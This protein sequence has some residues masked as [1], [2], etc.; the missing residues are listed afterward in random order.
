MNI[1]D[2]ILEEIKALSIK[3]T[4]QEAQ[5]LCKNYAISHF[6]VIENDKL[7]GCFAE[8]DIRTIEDTNKQLEEFIHLFNHFFVTEKTPFLDLITLFANN[9]S[10]L[11]PVLNKQHF[12]IGYYELSDV[13]ELFAASPFLH[14][15]NE[16]LVISKTENDYSMSQIAQIVESNKSKLLG[17]YISDKSN[18]SVQITLKI[19]STEINEIIQ[20][21]RRYDYTVLTEHEDDFYLEE[22]KDRANYLKKYLDL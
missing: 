14:R 10:N 22:L 8:G 3:D 6:P 4:V 13:L 11:I 20:T 2:Y 15:D 16:T 18:D 7:V 17:I 9:D 1:N 21:F 12:Y 19:S 5:E